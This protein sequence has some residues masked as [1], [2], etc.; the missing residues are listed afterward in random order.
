[1][2]QAELIADI[3]CSSGG[4][5]W[6]AS[7]GANEA[8]AMNCI[9]WYEAFAFCTWDGGRLATEAEWEYAAAGGSFNRR[10]PWGG[11][12]ATCDQANIFGC[13][14]HFDYV[15]NYPAGNGRWGHADLIGN[16]FEWVLDSYE[17][18]FYGDSAATGTDVAFLGTASSRVLRGNYWQT[19]SAVYLRSAY[20]GYD[21]PTNINV[22]IGARC[23][24][25]P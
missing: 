20:R 16:V 18:A 15:G 2:D 7:A 9:G 6:T 8:K 17:V 1:V 22:A 3:T 25:A 13:L 4:S 19:S 11:A 23:A 12:P 21:S 14:D 5:M 10:Y 24:R